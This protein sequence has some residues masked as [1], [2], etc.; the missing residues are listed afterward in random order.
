M[1][2][3]VEMEPRYNF[4]CQVFMGKNGCRYANTGHPYLTWD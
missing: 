3:Y 2:I 4:M 1:A